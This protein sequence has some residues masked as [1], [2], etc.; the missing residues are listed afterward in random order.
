MSGCN[1]QEFLK[2]EWGTRDVE[3][4]LAAKR[5]NPALDRILTDNEYLAIR[6]YTSNLYEHINPALRAGDAGKWSQLTSEAANGLGKLAD[7]GYVYSGDVV[8]NLH[9]TDDQVHQLFPVN[10]VFSD[11]AF[12]ST[13]SDLGGVFPGKVTMRI[14]SKTGVSVSSMSEY[15][16]EA[17]VLFSPSTP[18]KVL[19]RTQDPTK[20]TWD[21]SLEEL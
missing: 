6:G 14:A 4:A 13:T 8:R 11:R 20:G 12:L 5:L 17:E 16:R 18:F 19:G 3:D 15:P 7:N 2:R 1:F 10:G 21:I 9:L